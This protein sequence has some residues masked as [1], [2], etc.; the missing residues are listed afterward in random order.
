MEV[1]AWGNDPRREEV[2]P[3]FIKEQITSV[4]NLT[5]GLW[6]TT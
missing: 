3:G 6:E 2:N 1:G 5:R 4:D